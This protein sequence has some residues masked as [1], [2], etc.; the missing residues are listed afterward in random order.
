MIKGMFT[1][2]FLHSQS[3]TDIFP[4]PRIQRSAAAFADVELFPVALRVRAYVP[5]AVPRQG[6]AIQGVAPP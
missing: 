2:S 6:R 3:V 4:P 1:R 5:F